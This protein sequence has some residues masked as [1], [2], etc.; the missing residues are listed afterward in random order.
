MPSYF[1]RK[2]TRTPSPAARVGQ[3]ET[4]LAKRR[5]TGE[6]RAAGLERSTDRRRQD[7]DATDYARQ[8]AQASFADFEEDLGRGIET[9][10]GQQVGMGRLK[11]GFADEDEDRLVQ[12]LNARTARELARGAFTAGSLDLQNTAGIQAGAEFAREGSD[13]ALAGQLDRGDLA[14]ERQRAKRKGFLGKLGA[15]AGGVGGFFLGG[16]AGAAAGAR[17]GGSLGG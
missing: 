8:A 10:R 13:A 2:G 9:V 11:T 6:E 16:P 12:D 1:D 4:D 5:T 17:I 15:V 3:L 14:L 7:F